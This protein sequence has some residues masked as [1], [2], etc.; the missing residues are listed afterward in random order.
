MAELESDG[1]CRAK[2]VS[3]IQ[4]IVEDAYAQRRISRAQNGD[5]IVFTIHVPHAKDGPISD[6]FRFAAN[7]VA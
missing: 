5:E 4:K 6:L 2:I 7:V 3:D 1:V